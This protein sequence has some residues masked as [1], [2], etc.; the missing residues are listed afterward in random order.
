MKLPELGYA[1]WQWFKLDNGKANLAEDVR[2]ALA[3]FLG[4]FIDAGPAHT[5]DD[6]PYI[7]RFFGSIASNL[8]ARLPGYTGS[9]TRDLRR[10]LS[11]PRGNLRLYVSLAEI[12]ELLEA[13]IAGYNA[14][15]HDGLNG[16]TPLEAIEH[17][18][19]NRGALLTWLPEAKRRTLCLMQTPKR[20][21]V[22][23]YLD[24]GQ[25]PHINFHGVR[26]TNAA[27][28]STTAFLGQTLRVYYSSQD[29]RTV[30]AFAPDGTEMGV[31]KAQG[32]WGEIVHDLKL[33]QEVLR[34]RGRKRLTGALTQEFLQAF[35][36]Q[37]LA[38]ARGRRRAASDLAQTLR[39]L[40]AAPTSTGAPVPPAPDSEPAKET[41]APAPAPRVEP[42]RLS[43]RSGYVGTV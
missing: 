15:P 26:Y 17:S 24:Q 2:H 31:L 21:T 5:P 3:E 28:A 25:R 37:K 14:S 33:R 20:A 30:R 32:A 18:V 27:L 9:N 35:I 42:E 7:E 43:I 13:A 1:C 6:R 36:E 16:R 19:R 23:G 41:S 12:E 11:D 10:A 40:A 34:L 38:R 4:C 39:A 22:R 8:S 29:L